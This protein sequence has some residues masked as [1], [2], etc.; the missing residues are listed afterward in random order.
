MGITAYSS[1][2][3]CFMFT[4]EIVSGG[5]HTNTHTH[6]LSLPVPLSLQPSH[7]E[8]NRPALSEMHYFCAYLSALQ[9]IMF[10]FYFANETQPAVRM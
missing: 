3:E 1:V 10:N 7:N 6:T 2:M 5:F 4:T 9:C 8:T